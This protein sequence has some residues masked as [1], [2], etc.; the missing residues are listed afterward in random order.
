MK[1]RFWNSSCFWDHDATKV[2]GVTTFLHCETSALEFTDYFDFVN[3]SPITHWVPACMRLLYS[4][5][6][7]ARLARTYGTSH[8]CLCNLSVVYEVTKLS[9]ECSHVWQ[10]SHDA[11]ADPRDVP[12]VLYSTLQKNDPARRHEHYSHVYT[13]GVT[14]ELYCNSRD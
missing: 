2:F 12:K 3:I 14:C 11:S 6:K 7:L 8:K 4:T 5:V 13:C 1:Q 10:V 9:S